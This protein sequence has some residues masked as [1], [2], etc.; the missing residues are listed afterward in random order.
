MSIHYI[1][2]EDNTIADALSHLPPDPSEILTEDVDVTDAPLQWECWQGQANSCNAILSISA[3][4]SFL[5][6][7]HEGYKHDDFCKK[8]STVDSSIP[9]ICWENELWYLRD[10]LVIP[11]F[12]TL[13]KDLFCLAH[14]S[15]GHFGAKKSY[16]SIR[17]C[18]YWPNI[19]KD[20]ENAYV[21]ACAEC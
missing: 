11:R 4:K 1:C 18:Y 14:D 12:G 17:D 16:A 9:G 8:L 3:D 2:G 7:I 21:L 19:C 15:L 20:L 6:T 13:C 5:Q 10:C